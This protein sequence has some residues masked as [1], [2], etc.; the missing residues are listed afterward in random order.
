MRTYKL[1]TI[2][3]KKL[4]PMFV[5]T[6]KEMEIGKWLQAEIGELSD[7]THVKSKIGSLALR[8]GFHSTEVPFTDWIGKKAPDGRL[9][10]RPDTI[11][12]E[13]EV[14]GNEVEADR[15]GLKQIPDGWYY[16][17]TKAKQPFPWIISKEIKIIRRLSQSEVEEICERHGVK[18]QEIYD[19]S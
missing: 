14:R 3:N 15:K 8:P 5:L 6:N 1:L 17:R 13:C 19:G 11:W 9:L 10:Q 4:Y 7:T 2:K 12:C 16:F 18:A